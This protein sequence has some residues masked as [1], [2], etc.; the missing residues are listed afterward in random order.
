[1]CAL[2]GVIPQRWKREFFFVGVLLSKCKILVG[3]A[4]PFSLI[5]IN[6]V[7]IL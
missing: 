1:M 4:N 7:V 3:D 6:V 2:P 5:V